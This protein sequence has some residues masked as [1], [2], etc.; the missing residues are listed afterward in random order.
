MNI[1]YAL[2]FL[3]QEENQLLACPPHLARKLPTSLQQLIGYKQPSGS[4]NYVAECQVGILASMQQ[5][6]NLSLKRTPLSKV[7]TKTATLRPFV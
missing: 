7:N 4:L 5:L 2:A 3:A 1:N 6:C